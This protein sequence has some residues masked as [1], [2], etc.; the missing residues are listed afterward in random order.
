MPSSSPTL[1]AVSPLR[2]MASASCGWLA[3]HTSCPAARA[4]Q[5]IGTML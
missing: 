2:L 5:A 4:A 3:T 1:T